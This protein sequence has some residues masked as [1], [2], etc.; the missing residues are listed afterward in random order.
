MAARTTNCCRRRD[1]VRGPVGTGASSCQRRRVLGGVG[2]AMS[3]ASCVVTRAGSVRGR[4]GT[5][6]RL[7]PL[8]GGWIIA[9]S[10]SGGQGGEAGRAACCLS[11]LAP[12]L[13]GEGGEMQSPRKEPAACPCCAG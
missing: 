8:P 4:P 10:R 9:G 5:G 2:S 12:V 13:G 6:G 3:G 11:P 1:G 7:Q